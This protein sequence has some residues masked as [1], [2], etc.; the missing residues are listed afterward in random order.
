MKFKFS[1]IS[2][3]LASGLTVS[4][5]HAQTNYNFTNTTA[6][7]FTNG[8]VLSGTLSTN[9]SNAVTAANLSISTNGGTPITFTSLPTQSGTYTA[10]LCGTSTTFQEYRFGNGSPNTLYLDV[11]SSQLDSALAGQTSG[12]H[13]SLLLSS[14]S[15]ALNSACGGVYDASKTSR[16]SDM[17]LNAAQV[18]QSNSSIFPITG[19][20]GTAVPR[21]LNTIHSGL[22]QFNNQFGLSAIQARLSAAK[23]AKAREKEMLAIF[24]KQFAEMKQRLLENP[25]YLAMSPERQAQELETLTKLAMGKAEAQ[26]ARMYPQSSREERISRAKKAEAALQAQL[27]KQRGKNSGD[28]DLTAEI[29][30]QVE[31]DPI[32]FWAQPFSSSGEQ[33]EMDNVSPFKT[34]AYGVT[35]GGDQ[36]IDARWTVGGGVMLG[37]STV[38]STLADAPNTTST[39]MYQLMAY[40]QYA[41]DDNTSLQLTGSLGLNQNTNSRMTPDTSTAV[42]KYDSHVMG[43]GMSVSRGYELDD[44]TSFTPSVGIN[45]SR[46]Q[47]AQINETGAGNWNITT[48]KHSIEQGILSLGG[49]VRHEMSDEWTVSAKLGASYIFH[50][51]NL[52]VVSSFAGLPSNTFTST[53]SAM[54]PWMKTV[55]LGATYTS[56]EGT[57][58]NFGY[59]AMIR[60][61]FL[62]HSAYVKVKIPF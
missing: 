1:S 25:M 56:P 59:D 18:V 11:M 13:T 16:H 38:S 40:G 3:A 39:N 17:T 46:Q 53:G 55:G 15:Y 44:A 36:K 35:F 31:E 29:L 26:I 30:A 24:N 12:V 14:G 9:A 19:N 7:T 45:Y 49:Q 47:N 4:G 6:N 42:S 54:S 51:P 57:Q 2:L 28:D 27:K 22:T 61:K 21:L 50:N 33:R 48:Y 41:I 23:A 32:E 62:N 10:T 43:L 37:S 34:R 5:V 58:V 60:E 8:Y 20:S 52:T